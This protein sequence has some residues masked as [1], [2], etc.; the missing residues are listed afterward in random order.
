MAKFL[1]PK[2]K[3]SRR[4]NLD[5]YLKSGIR[6][7]SL[8][9]NIE[10]LPGQI[11]SRKV[12]LS[13]Y[14]LQ[15]REKQKVKRIYGILEKQFRNYYK[16][17]KKL[18]GNT[19]INLLQLIELRLDN[20]IYR[21]GFSSTRAEAKQLINHKLV[22]VNN[23]IVNV[24]SYQIMLN[25]I[26]K[27]NEKSINQK[28]IKLSLNINNKRIKSKWVNVDYKLFQGYL[29]RLPNRLDIYSNINE[30]LIIGL[31]SK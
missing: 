26:V 3:L 16:K 1:G 18:K 29:L 25:D 31:Y 12:R 6:D 13:D 5:L 21:M 11:N 9:C 30:Q 20:I 7:I 19:S 27:I 8:K 4:E 24:P 10:K 2:L 22:L 14:A 17:A 15:L 23:K 28:R